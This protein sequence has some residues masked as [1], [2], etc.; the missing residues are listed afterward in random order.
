MTEK[1]EAELAE[2]FFAIIKKFESEMTDI[3]PA[4]MRAREKAY[5]DLKE[6]LSVSSQERDRGE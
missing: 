3:I 2:V 4:D 5:R 1:K 6:R